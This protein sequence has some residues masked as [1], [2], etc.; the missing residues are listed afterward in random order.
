MATENVNREWGI[1]NHSRLPIKY[2]RSMTVDDALLDKLARLSA[3][4]LPEEERAAIKAELEKMIGFISRLQSL[5]TG[6]T[7]PLVHPGAEVAPL[8]P[9][10][11]GGTLSREAALG[12]APQT[13]GTF[14]LVPRVLPGEKE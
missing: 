13:D 10:E 1:V 9:D 5:D 3:L 7:A 11:R 6:G 2:L 8:R 14:F 12:N 4:D